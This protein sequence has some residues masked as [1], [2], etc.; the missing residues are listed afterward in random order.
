MTNTLIT[1]TAGEGAL[2]AVYYSVL[3]ILAIFGLH[4]LV[5]IRQLPSPGAP[6][7]PA[8]A[9]PAVWPSVT[10]QLPLY[11]EPNVAARLVDAVSRFEYPGAL[12]IQVLDDSTDVTSSLVAEAVEQARARGVSIEQI[13]RSSRD[14]YKAGALSEGLCRTESELVAIFDA[15]FVPGS[16]LLLR[17]VPHFADAGVGMVQA[18]WGHLNRERSLLTRAQAVYLDAH[19]AVESAARYRTGNFFNFNGTA[20]IWRRRAI[21][22]AGGWSASTL[23][24]DLDLSYRAQ[25]AGWRFVFL[26][27]FEVPAELPESLAAFHSQQRRWAKGSIQTAR[28]I[29]PALWRTDAPRSVKL[30]ATFHLCNNSAYLF[31][32]ILATLVVPAMAIRHLSGLDWTIAIDAVL[33]ALSTGSVVAFYREGQR[34]VGRRISRRELF[35]VLPVGI[36]MS[37]VNAAAVLEGLFETGGHFS[38]TPKSGNGQ[39]AVAA[40]RFKGF[41]MAESILGTFFLAATALFLAQGFYLA[42]PFLL[43]FLS[44]YTHVALLRAIEIVRRQIPVRR[45]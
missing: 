4:R 28:R 39:V 44:G 1:M 8:P 17:M 24:E 7:A 40:D 38:R 30:E 21:D 22:D 15:D 10:V 13:R 18:R 26:P 12:H 27:G 11:N 29:L 33:F 6:V 31:T 34:R 45:G 23:T 3:A 19:F 42:I 16:D 37:A 2:L 36:G 14:G 43:L 25:L 20:G 32:L 41:P 9:D 5:L 35:A